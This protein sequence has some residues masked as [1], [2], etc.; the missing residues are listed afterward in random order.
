MGNKNDRLEAAKGAY[1]EGQLLEPGFN[2][3]TKS[4]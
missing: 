3:H 1:A 4:E 2:R